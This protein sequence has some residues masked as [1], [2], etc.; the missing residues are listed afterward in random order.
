MSTLRALAILMLLVLVA[1]AGLAQTY[2]VDWNVAASGGGTGS[3]ASYRLSCTVAQPASG[4]AGST[5]RLHWI[6][7]WSGDVPPP[8]ICS[9]PSAAKLQAD[10]V[11]VS[12]A[13]QIA[14]SALQDF[15]TFFYVEDSLRSSGI[16]VNIPPVAVVNL[17]RGS[18]VNVIGTI[19]TA[20]NGE[21]QLSGPIAIVTAGAAPLTALGMSSK[22][23]GGQDFGVPPLGQYG[24]TGSRGLNNVGLLVKTWG[25]VTALGDGYVVVSDGSGSVRLDTTALASQPG[26][27]SYITVAGISNLYASGD[28]YS[29][30]VP[31]NSAD[32]KTW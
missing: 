24:V 26:L 9:S 21:R 29:L 16:R 15:A 10:G 13:G 12:V 8:V 6:G 14:T 28:I 22:S 17:A 25:Q 32:I 2:K 3:S 31:R 20:A 5:N 27:H 1:T 7:F 4:F 11:F 23:I 19:S 18:V 30:I